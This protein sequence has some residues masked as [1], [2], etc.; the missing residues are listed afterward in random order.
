MSAPRI[1]LVRHGEVHNPDGILYGRLPGFRLSTLGE[2]MADAAAA[3]FDGQVVAR[4]YASP[5]ERAQQ[6]AAPWAKRFG[7]EIRTE[8]RI[9]EPQNSFEGRSFEAGPKALLHPESWPLLRNPFRPSW[10]EPY[11]IIAGRVIHAMQDAVTELQ[12]SGDEGDI[13]MVSHQ[14]P[15]WITHRRLAGERLWHDPRQRRCSLSSI[16]SFEARGDTF[17]EVEYAEPA[18]GLGQTVDVGAV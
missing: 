7:V 10:G 2:H 1:H 5:L 14:S 9:I 13:V 4:L 6:S 12:A 8:R 11:A 16:T 3:S 17:V 18:A 15:I